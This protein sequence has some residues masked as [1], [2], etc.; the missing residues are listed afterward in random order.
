MLSYESKNDCCKRRSP[1]LSPKIN[2]IT[3]TKT[4]FQELSYQL[5]W[6]AS[7]AFASN[8]N[9]VDTLEMN[10]YYQLPP[11]RLHFSFRI[12]IH[13]TS[14]SCSCHKVETVACTVTGYRISVNWLDSNR[15]A[16]KY[17]YTIFKYI[18]LKFNVYFTNSKECLKSTY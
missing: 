9:Q 17:S 5:W 18:F 8:A 14:G 6:T 2:S 10:S 1:K 16:L 13:P 4:I 7:F 3:V 12:D 15:I 11:L